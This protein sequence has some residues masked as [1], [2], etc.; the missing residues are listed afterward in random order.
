MAYHIYHTEALILGGRASG[1]GDRMLYCYTRE[2]GLVT[3]HVKSLRESRSRLR[4]TLQTF[5]HAELDLIQGKHGWKLI[6]ARPVNSFAHIWSD[7]ERR[8]VLAQHASLIRRLIQ[9][10]EPHV[11]LF[12]DLLLGLE[13][14]H[15]SDDVDGLRAVE[16]LLVIRLLVRLGYWGDEHEH[17]LLT[18]A[19]AW[20][21]LGLLYTEGNRDALLVRVNHA[22]RSSQL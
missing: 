1:E 19:D 2:L 7:I 5:A 11:E 18:S 13:L 14:L 16:L 15:A 6:S 22:L 20:S 21:P 17:T 8:R 9:G 3:A 4:Y 12:D 10:E